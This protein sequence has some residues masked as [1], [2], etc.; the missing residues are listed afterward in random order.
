MEAVA[1][2][3]GSFIDYWDHGRWVTSGLSVVLTV[4]IAY[5][6]LLRLRSSLLQPLVDCP[7]LEEELN[8]QPRASA[9]GKRTANPLVSPIK[10]V[11]RLDHDSLEVQVTRKG[12]EKEITVISRSPSPTLAST[13]STHKTISPSVNPVRLRPF[14][15]NIRFASSSS[16]SVSSTSHKAWPR[17]YHVCEVITGLDAIKKKMD[18][19]RLSQYAAFG[20]VFPGVKYNKGQMST[21]RTILSRA[22]SILQQHFEDHGM[23]SHGT[24]RAFRA[25]LPQNIVD[26]VFSDTK[27]IRDLEDA[28]SDDDDDEVIS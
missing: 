2:K 26:K 7:G 27:A 12:K 1:Y 14:P 23:T 17:D 4:N 22:G 19:E 15:L 5:H 3:E 21:T 9:G 10:K 11:P 16:A 18:N 6:V 24:W 25:F 8:A 13:S 20:K 28:M